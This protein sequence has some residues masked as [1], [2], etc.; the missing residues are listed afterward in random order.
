MMCKASLGTRQ[1]AYD[2]PTLGHEND[3]RI[4][5]LTFK[6]IAHRTHTDVETVKEVAKRTHKVGKV[7]RVDD[8][9]DRLAGSAAKWE[10]ITRY[11]EK[12]GVREE[13]AKN[14]NPVVSEWDEQATLLPYVSC[15]APDFAEA[16]SKVAASAD[17]DVTIDFTKSSG[18]RISSEQ[19]SVC[20]MGGVDKDMDGS[21]VVSVSRETARRL[22]DF[23]ADKRGTLS[24][25]IVE[26]TE[27]AR[28]EANGMCVVSQ[29]KR[30]PAMRPSDIE[31]AKPEA[32]QE[33]KPRKAEKAKPVA[34]Q[35]EQKPVEQADVKP[36]PVEPSA[37]TQVIPEV[38]PKTTDTARV[39]KVSESV[40]PA[41]VKFREL[42]GMADVTRHDVRKIRDSHGRK[43]GYV[44]RD[45]KAVRILWREWYQH[46]D[47]SLDATVRELA[48]SWAKAA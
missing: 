40:I 34:K 7:W 16:M 48:E 32:K 13:V 47:A 11:L 19:T 46:D 20:V 36:E 3:W 4:N 43:V 41:M 31:Q 44:V 24:F 1:I 29:C 21:G 8:D 18:V 45:G 5:M 25:G 15:D 39:V 27:I 26:H 12:Q 2:A 33:A 35:V 6:G 30:V 9:P 28:V 17:G 23:A 10:A 37:D 38:P 42:P 22:A 14:G